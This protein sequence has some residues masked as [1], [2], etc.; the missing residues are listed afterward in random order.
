MSSIDL[1][2]G[3]HDHQAQALAGLSLTKSLIE[4]SFDAYDAAGMAAARA[5]LSDTLQSYQQ[6]KH[7]CIFNPAIVSGDP[8]RA[9]RARTMKIACIAAGEEYRH[10]IQTW[11]GVFGHDRW[12]EYRLSTLNLIKRLRDHIDTERRALDD[13]ATMY[14]KAA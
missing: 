11:T 2:A 4:T 5:V 14:P 7:E 12:A 13:L 3:Y 1:F 10:F 6:L 8:A 9:D